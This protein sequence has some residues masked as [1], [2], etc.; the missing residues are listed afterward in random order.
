MTI[1]VLLQCSKSKTLEIEQDLFWS[2]KTTLG[3]WNTA[4]KNAEERI[5]TCK[6]YSGRA[7]NREFN[8]L[9]SNDAVKGYVISAGAGLVD[10]EE[11]I[12][13]YESTFMPNLG[14]SFA[15]W[16]E[17][18]NGGL[19]N[20][21]VGKSDKIVTFAAPN[22]HKALLADP[23]FQ[24]LAPKFVVAH[25]SPLS[26]AK[27]VTSIPVHPRAGEH[28]GVALIDLNSELLKVYL[29][30]EEKGFETLYD[31]CEKLPPPVKRRTVSDEELMVVVESLQPLSS[32]TKSV[33]YIR[34]TLGI[35]A[36]YERIRDTILDVR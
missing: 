21:K 15:Q 16:S 9:K 36:S 34:H 17:L 6:L 10:L 26:A 1:H 27:G 20:L 32:I 18:P 14:P 4:W 7:I 19:V 25:T 33:E 11:K 12:P 2:E 29:A 13:S 35:S 28:L 31:E 3:S 22:Y 8:L 5:A 23:D 30:S 24:T